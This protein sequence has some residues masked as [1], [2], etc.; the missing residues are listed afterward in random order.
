MNYTYDNDSRLTQVTDPTG[1]YQFT[2][3]NMG[4]LTST[5]TFKYDPF[6]RRIY[7]SSANGTSIY[8]YE[9]NN[10]IEEANSSGGANRPGH[11]CVRV[12]EIL[13]PFDTN[14]Q[15]GSGATPLRTQDL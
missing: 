2:F 13:T 8:A 1:T 11:A 4:R 5:T 12:L 15:K 3:D 9:G 10:L 14:W 6:G 7:K